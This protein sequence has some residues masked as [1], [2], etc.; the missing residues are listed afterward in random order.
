MARGDKKDDQM[1]LSL[2][3]TTSEAQAY[4]RETSRLCEEILKRTAP[5]R[6]RSNRRVLKEISCRLAEVQWWK[7]VSDKERLFKEPYR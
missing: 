6:W 4:A 5:W 2:D 1:P 7:D 3:A